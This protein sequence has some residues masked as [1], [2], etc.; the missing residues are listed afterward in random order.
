M[1]RPN[2]LGRAV[3]TRGTPHLRNGSLAQ[4][5][6]WL[7][8]EF[9]TYASV[10]SPRLPRLAVRISIGTIATPL[11]GRSQEMDGEAFLFAREALDEARR[12]SPDAWLWF[13]TPDEALDL[14]ANAIALLLGVVKSRWKPLHWRRAHLRDQGWSEEGIGEEEGVSQVAVTYSLDAAGY[15]AVRQ[16]EERLVAL[17]SRRWP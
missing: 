3:S 1:P 13:R 8:Q 9:H 5:A 11:R 7:A 6:R 4:A 10:E 16:A 14:A 17:L 12:P 2:S 15:S